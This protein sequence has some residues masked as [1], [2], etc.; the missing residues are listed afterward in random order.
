M[1]APGA[2]PRAVIAR[3]NRDLLKVLAMRDVQDDLRKHGLELTG[4]TPEE[5]A[6]HIKAEKAV[7]A[8]VIKDAGIK[9][10]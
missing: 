3:L 6:A 4:S 7:W 8:K 9:P 2:T 5:F 1:L 10:E